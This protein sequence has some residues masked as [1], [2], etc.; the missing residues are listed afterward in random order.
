M[1]TAPDTYPENWRTV[2][3]ISWILTIAA[4]AVVAATGRSM[5]R[6]PWWLGPSTNPASPLA[7][8][9]PL[10]C[11]VVPLVAAFYKPAYIAKGGL[12]CSS[13]LVVISA[14]DFLK[15]PSIAV[16]MTVVSVASLLSSIALVL[17]TRHYR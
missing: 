11:V 3:V 1:E 15:I 7:I 13:A 8:L 5:G 4:I 17:A 6:S 14:V 12:A 16:A 9:L 2:A 10:A